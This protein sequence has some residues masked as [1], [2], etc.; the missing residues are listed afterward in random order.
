MGGYSNGVPPLPIPNREVKPVY[1]DGTAVKCGRVGSRLFKE[2]CKCKAPFF[3]YIPVACYFGFLYFLVVVV[4]FDGSGINR[5]PFRFRS[6][7]W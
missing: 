3:V 4:G 1:A 5:S 2:L 6:S 7:V